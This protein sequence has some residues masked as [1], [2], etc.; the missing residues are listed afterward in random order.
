[1]VNGEIENL[2]KH[3]VSEKVVKVWLNFHEHKTGELHKKH[4]VEA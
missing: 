3:S 4:A 2:E 1:L